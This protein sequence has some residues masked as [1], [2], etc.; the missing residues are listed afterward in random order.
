MSDIV[1]FDEDSCQDLL[2]RGFDQEFILERTGL[3]VGYHGAKLKSKL[4]GIDRDCYKIA[5][6]RNRCSDDDL[7]E[8]VRQISEGLCRDDVLNR[9]GL[10]QSVHMS[11]AKIF[12]G[13]GFGVMFKQAMKQYQR[14]MMQ[15]GSVAKF[16]VDNVFKLSE[17]QEQSKQTRKDKYGA[18]YTLQNGSVLA[19]SVRQKIMNTEKVY[20]DEIL[21]KRKHTMIERYGVE[22]PVQSEVCRRRMQETC[23]ARYGVPYY[24]MLR[25]K[26]KLKGGH[27]KLKVRDPESVQKAVLKGQETQRKHYGGKL[28]A[29]TDEGRRIIGENSRLC[30]AESHQKG[31]ETSMT[32]Y[33]VDHYSKTDEFKQRMSEYMLSPDNQSRIHGRTIVTNLERY[34][35]PYA[36]QAERFRKQQSERMLNPEYN[37]RIMLAKKANGTFNTS[38]PEDLCCE[39][40]C[41]IF[42][43]DNV[44]RNY[45][46]SDRYP[47]HC[48]FYVKSLDLFCELNAHWTH[49]KHWF[50]EM[51]DEDVKRRDQWLASEKEFYHVAVETWCVRDVRKRAMAA[52]HQL[53]YLVLW[54]SNLKDLDL[55]LDLGMLKPYDWKRMYSWLSVRSI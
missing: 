30:A 38:K 45:Y 20:H 17:F 1:L 26:S 35:V 48:D 40:F 10:C 8:L 29:Q 37:Q 21:E 41:D 4:S 32:R 5:F 27:V 42:G 25:A 44:I 18:E 49:G 50:E 46:D 11:L 19:E 3:D 55:W 34:G 54:D 31:R 23:Q 13:L 52:K 2:L 7:Q 24:S 12:D 43:R 28:W 51:C 14:K 6:V 15:D 36:T 33:G 16:G 53:C 47:F 22:F 9:M 39:R